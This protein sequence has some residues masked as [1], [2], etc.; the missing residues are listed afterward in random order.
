MLFTFIY[1][2]MVLFVRE[3]AIALMVFADGEAV[4]A[5][6]VVRARLHKVS[7]SVCVNAAMMLATQFSLT[8]M[9]SLQSGLLPNSQV[10]PLWSTRLCRKRYAALTQTDSCAWYKPA[11]MLVNDYF[12]FSFNT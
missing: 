1:L 12:H 11:L 5:I 7:E 9:E 4:E 3:S 2:C 6:T 8:T 10:T